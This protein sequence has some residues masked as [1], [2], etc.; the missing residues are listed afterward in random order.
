MAK[1]EAI[2]ELQNCIELIRQDGQEC[3]MGLFYYNDYD[4]DEDYDW[5]VARADAQNIRYGN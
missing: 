5:D 2:Q 1:K 3:P 4:D